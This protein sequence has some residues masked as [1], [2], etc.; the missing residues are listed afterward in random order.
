MVAVIA[1]ATVIGSRR[2][3]HRQLLSSTGKEIRR[4]RRGFL[5]ALSLFARPPARRL[6]VSLVCVAYFDHVTEQGPRE[7]TDAMH[8]F[9]QS[10]IKPSVIIDVRSWAICTVLL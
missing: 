4:Y 5:P 6:I 8:S 7:P 9:V 1:D 3:R 10:A 2:C